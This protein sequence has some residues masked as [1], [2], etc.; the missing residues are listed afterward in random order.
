MCDT[1]APRNATQVSIGVLFWQF[2]N[3]VVP[4]KQAKR[5]YPLFGQL[6]SLAPVVAGLCVV[7]FTNVGRGSDG[8]GGKVMAEP[9]LN[10]ILVR[11]IMITVQDAPPGVRL[12][13]I[14]IY[15]Y[16][17][18]CICVFSHCRGLGFAVRSRS[19][20]GMEHKN[21]VVFC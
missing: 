5:F 12:A 1:A 3:D 2:A 13:C 10:F 4:V 15:I 8:G 21:R 14:C 20:A 19:S 11:L 17:Y 16:T 6:S 9:L 18:I 7:R